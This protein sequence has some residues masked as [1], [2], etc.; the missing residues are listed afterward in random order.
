M[1]SALGLKRPGKPDGRGKLLINMVQVD[2][3][4]FKAALTNERSALLSISIQNRGPLTNRGLGL[5]V[6]GDLDR[7]SF[8]DLM[9]PRCPD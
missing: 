3:T 8:F 2:E 9:E 7:K 1:P 4:R 5:K 6:C